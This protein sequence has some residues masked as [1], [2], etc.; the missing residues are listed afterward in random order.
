MMIDMSVS[1]RAL[2][3]V[4]AA[5]AVEKSQAPVS[6]ETAHGAAALA[7]PATSPAGSI[8][9]VKPTQNFNPVSLG[10][11][12][13]ELDTTVELMVLLFRIA[14]KAREMGVLQRDSE[15]TAIIEAQKSQ[16]AEM[17]SGAN[18]MIAM[19]VISGIMAVGT[20]VIG[21]VGAS[22]NGKAIKQEG[23]LEKSIA[24]RNELIDA[25]MQSLGK[26]TDAERKTVAAPW[27]QAQEFDSSLLNRTGK[28]ID[29]RNTT[30]QAING[31]NQSLGQ[32]ANTSV[33]V[34]QGEVQANAKEDEVDASI[35]QSR[36][37]IVDEQLSYNSNSMK[38][39]I[40]TLHE[41]S[42]NYVAAWRA[43]AAVV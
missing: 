12:T 40:Q 33:Q 18:L 11:V 38:E 16:V 10:K 14:Q 6:R 3:E 21:A 22:K 31:V 23:Q 19:A 30:F 32:M 34:R 35:A 17:R 43:A 5:A 29:T 27:A 24:G 4:G 7:A 1:P 36:K 15:N 26:T 28:K 13:S 20:A 41:L 2:G 39:L 42:Q 37:Q 8:E 9:L 25:K